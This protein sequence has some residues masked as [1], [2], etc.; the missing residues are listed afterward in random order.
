MHWYGENG[1]SSLKPNFSMPKKPKKS[2]KNQIFKLLQLVVLF[3]E[4]FLGVSS[5]RDCREEDEIEIA[6]KMK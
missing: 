2:V 3:L 4:D 5:N 6:E 1:I